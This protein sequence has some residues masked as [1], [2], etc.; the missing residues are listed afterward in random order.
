[1]TTSK[2]SRESQIYVLFWQTKR[3]GSL[4]RRV[5][6]PNWLTYDRQTQ[7]L[8]SVY[9]G[10]DDRKLVVVIGVAGLSSVTET[11]WFLPHDALY[12]IAV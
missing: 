2:E 1:M 4:Q 9:F 8:L 3:T 10:I 12:A 11:V 7:F 6:Q 5:D